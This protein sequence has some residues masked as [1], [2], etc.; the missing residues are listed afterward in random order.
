MGEIQ[1]EVKVKSKLLANKNTPTFLRASAKGYFS[2]ASLN[3]NM[4]CK[5]TKKNQIWKI[6]NTQNMRGVHLPWR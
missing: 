2:G 3:F 1:S 5:D 4:Q 6:K